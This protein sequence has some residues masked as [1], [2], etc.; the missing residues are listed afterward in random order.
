[1][2]TFEVLASGAIL[3]TT[4]SAIT[5]EPFF[6]PDRIIVLPRA[7][8]VDTAALQEALDA[9]PTPDCAPPCF[10]QYALASWVSRLVA[11]EEE[12]G[13]DDRE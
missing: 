3:V 4:N 2:R 13:S 1:M 8:R 10:E 9:L 5:K 7:D 6:D 11:S 12:S